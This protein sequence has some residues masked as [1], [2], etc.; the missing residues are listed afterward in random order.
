MRSTEKNKPAEAMRPHVDTAEGVTTVTYK[1][2]VSKGDMPDPTVWQTPDGRYYASSTTHRIMTG[3]NLVDWE[4]TGKKLLPS[5]EIEWIKSQG[6]PHIWAP[7][8]AKIGDWYNLYICFHRTGHHTAIACYRSK[9]PDGPFTD[10]TILLT[11]EGLGVYEVIDPEVV[12]DPGTGRL[13][14]FFGHGSVRRVELT[15]D[16]RSLVWGAAITE[17]AAG[18]GC[19]GAY[20]HRRDGKWYLFVSRGSWNDHT[21]HL[22]VGRSDTID[23]VFLDKD[24][25][26]LTEG[27][28][29]VILASGK[30]DEFFGPGHNAEIY[31]MADGRDYML[32]HCHWTGMLPPKQSRYIPRPMFVQEILWGEDGWPYFKDGKVAA[33]GTVSVK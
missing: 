18:P 9:S 27:H 33:G 1:N 12:R 20:L 23:G 16:G 4:D 29:T 6:Y 17:V 10:R 19:E 11:S 8:V 22:R 31:T 32:Y 26:P 14:L 2:P 25:R 28:G 30:D 15:P 5:E 7:D 13:W 24:G 3:T 21:Y